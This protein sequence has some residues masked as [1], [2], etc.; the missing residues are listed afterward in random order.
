MAF[1]RSLEIGPKIVPLPQKVNL[2]LIMGF[3]SAAGIRVPGAGFG[4][5]SGFNLSFG[6]DLPISGEV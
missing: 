3:H 4:S 5:L 2:I 1:Y 6:I